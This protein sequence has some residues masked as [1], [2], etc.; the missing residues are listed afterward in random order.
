MAES[1]K[2]P[3]G[4]SKPYVRRL[5]SRRDLEGTLGPSL[6]AAALAGK[7]SEALE[8]K[9]R[10]LGRA[11]MLTPTEKHIQQMVAEFE[12][13]AESQLEMFRSVIGTGQSTL[14]SSLLLNG[15]AAIAVLG[16]IGQIA[17]HAENLSLIGRLAFPL[18]GFV[19]GTLL[20]ALAHGAVYF[21]QKTYFQ[22]SN[23]AGDQWNSI[24]IT[25]LCSSFAFF[26]L[27]GATAFWALIDSSTSLI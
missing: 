10:D 18:L 23:A 12:A 19:L 22:G 5:F 6:S 13:K 11:G 1:P 24:A 9:Q 8:A 26:A 4:E 16:F 21:A 17:A 2:G 7:I 27:G 3:K 20:S 14:K 15:G 25:L